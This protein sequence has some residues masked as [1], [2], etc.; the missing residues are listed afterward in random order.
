MSASCF[1]SQCWV[2][3]L[4]LFDALQCSC[5]CTS[6]LAAHFCVPLYAL[7]DL[8][9]VCDIF[10]AVITV[11]EEDNLDVE[12]EEYYQNLKSVPKDELRRRHAEKPKPVRK[13]NEHLNF[14]FF[15]LGKF[16]RNLITSRMLTLV[17]NSIFIV[18]LTQLASGIRMPW[19]MSVVTDLW[20]GLSSVPS[21]V[22]YILALW[23][24]A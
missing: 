2:L 20:M 10:S 11:A 5:W 16:F 12:I 17:T 4:E 1:A 6:M 7:N 22:A 13:F 14:S 9:H 19:L 15:K 3:A 24:I 8:P 23:I 21:T 18:S